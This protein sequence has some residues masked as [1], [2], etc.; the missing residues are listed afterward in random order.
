MEHAIGD[1]LET[2]NVLGFT[3]RQAEAWA[4]LASHR[5]LLY[6]GARGGGKSRFLRWGG[7]GLLMDHAAAGRRGVV[8]A[9]FCS[10]YPELRDRQVSKIDMEF[11]KWLG[12]L[13]DSQQFGLAFH[14]AEEYGGGVLQLRNLDDP[15]KYKS[16]EFAFILIDE[17]TQIA[18]PAVFHTLRGSLRWAGVRRPQFIAASN[19]DGPGNL[20]VRQLWIER[21]YPPELQPLADEFCFVQS[22]PTD[23]PHLDD[24]YWQD[25]KTLPPDL[26]RAWLE[27]DWYV[28]SGQAFKS[29]RTERHIIKPFEIPK[30][31]LRFRGIDWGYAS[32]FCCLWIARN[33]DNGRVVVYRELYG[34]ELT[35][36]QQARMIADL[37]PQ[38]ERISTSYADPSMW[39]RSTLDNVT[40]TADQYLAA[41]VQLTQADNNRLNGKRKIDRLLEDLP[42]GKPGL[43]V[44][45][46]CSNLIRTLPAMAYDKRH[47]EDIDTTQEDHAVDAL[48]YALTSLREGSPRQEKKQA[49]PWM[50]MKL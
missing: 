21:D 16:S 1:R 19:P 37:T 17:L 7:I 5:F 12:D 31:W 23:N 14:V 27:G 35:D 20:W 39:A 32:P 50:E 30:H 26:R 44:F 46:T 3:P 25:L 22:L 2:I 43:L 48:R 40:S 29:W 34:K 42:D 15:S 28:F 13:R 24:S 47:P 38:D 9:L 36:R 41:G 45:E 10:T 18:D 49:N 4:Q 8:G 33:P 6:G 11:P